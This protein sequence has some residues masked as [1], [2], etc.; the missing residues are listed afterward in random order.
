GTNNK[1]GSA[2]RKPSLLTRALEAREGRSFI[3]SSCLR[4]IHEGQITRRLPTFDP[5]V[6]AILFIGVVLQP[7]AAQ[8]VTNGFITAFL[9]SECSSAP[10]PPP[11]GQ[12]ATGPDYV[13][14]TVADADPKDWATAQH[15]V[16][17]AIFQSLMPRYCSLPKNSGLGCVTNRVQ[18]AI[19]T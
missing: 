14:M 11:S 6:L 19:R 13:I 10:V 4:S 18:W 3:V 16:T 5:K 9:S 17:D 2:M 12:I 7:A 8:T 15:L 1:E